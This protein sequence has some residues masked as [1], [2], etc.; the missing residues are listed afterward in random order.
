[1]KR[2]IFLT[3]STLCAATFAQIPDYV[4]TDGLVG[5]WTMNGDLNDAT[6]NYSGGQ[7]YG[8]E[9]VVDRNGVANGAISFDGVSGYV[10]ID[11][12]V[13]VEDFSISLWY[14]AD[15]EQTAVQTDVAP[16]VYVGRDSGVN[17]NVSGF[18][19]GFSPVEMLSFFGG[20]GTTGGTP[21]VPSIFD[22][23]THWTV[24]YTSSSQAMTFYRNGG[25]AGTATFPS[26]LNPSPQIFFGAVDPLAYSKFHGILD[27]VSIWSRALLSSEV[28]VLYSETSLLGCTDSGA[29]NFNVQAFVDDGSCHFNCQF[30][31][32]GTVWSEELG[33]CIGD[34]SGD[35]NLDGC[36][37]LNDLLDLLSAYGNCGAEEVPWQCGDPLAYQG[38]DYVTVQIGEQCWLAE[39]LRNELYQNGD[40][41]PAN[42]SD[43][44]W[45]NTDTGGVGATTVF[46][47]PSFLCEEFSPDGDGCD[48]AWSLTAYGRLYNWY[49]L[50]DARG[51]CPSGWHVP[52]D[53]EWTSLTNQFGGL[54]NSGDELKTAS[55]WYQGGNGSNASGFSALPG[56]IRNGGNG[57][58]QTAGSKAFFWTATENIDREF[59]Y[60]QDSVIRV[61]HKDQQKGMSVRCLKDLEE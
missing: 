44:E 28:E 13:D 38:Y 56:G 54:S 27:D 60:G 36:V 3:L 19:T 39:N 52:S 4:P 17:P 8:V 43:E 14:F 12:M 32:T 45:G 24:T 50:N 9:Y 30:C 6:G 7:S 40:S 11:G 58:F 51:L 31:L 46:G 26:F 10:E 29:C 23:W 21:T 41:I 59:T 16:L 57:S 49:A 1:M 37:Q 35:I 33:G 48:E 61:T 47:E 25:A 5:W 22:E 15:P 2:L 53:E 34:G 18:G 42:L 55:G 20:V